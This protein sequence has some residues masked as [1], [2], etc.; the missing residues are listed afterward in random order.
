MYVTVFVTPSSKR[1]SLEVASRDELY[2]TVREPAER[3][4]ANIAVREAVAEHFSLPV[5]RVRIISGH[6]ARKK[7]LSLDIPDG[8]E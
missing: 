7:V 2:I 1:A 5:A 3:N 8:V 4:M 6:R